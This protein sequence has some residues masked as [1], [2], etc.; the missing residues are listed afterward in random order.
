MAKQVEIY[1]TYKPSV[2]DPQGEA[3]KNALY[4]MDY[5]TVKEVRI[6]KYFELTIEE[7]NQPIETVIEEICDRLLANIQIET[8]QYKIMEE[9]Y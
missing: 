1:V 6:G 5:E 8:Y 2:F 7:D 9:V 4:R 3:V